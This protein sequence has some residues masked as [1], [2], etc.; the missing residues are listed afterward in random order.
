MR[1]GVAE[2]PENGEANCRRGLLNLVFASPAEAKGAQSKHVRHAEKIIGLDKS[3][4]RPSFLLR[5]PP[6]HPLQQAASQRIRRGVAERTG[7]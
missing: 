7:D 3:P 1:L 5:E 6:F 2:K 4:H